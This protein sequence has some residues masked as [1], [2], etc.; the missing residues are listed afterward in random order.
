MQ[1]KRR[2]GKWSKVDMNYSSGTFL[3]VLRKIRY[4]SLWIASLEGRNL[5]QGPPEEELITT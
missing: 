5:N 4:T 2:G 3:E 1:W